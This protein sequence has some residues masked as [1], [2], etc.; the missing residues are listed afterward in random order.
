M[1]GALRDQAQLLSAWEAAAALPPVARGAALVER[2]GL[3]DDLDAA[4]DLPVG[5]GAALA[6]RL[7]ADA[8]GDEVDG[9]VTCGACGTVLDVD[10]AAAGAPRGSR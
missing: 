9:L 2:A 7:Y 3:V 8:F 5:E 4:L 1:D 10:R 6:A